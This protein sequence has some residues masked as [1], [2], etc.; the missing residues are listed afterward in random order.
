MHGIQDKLGVKNMTYLKINVTK[1][2]YDTET[3]TKGQIKKYK[4]FGKE[5]TADLTGIYIHE[6]LAF[7]IIMYS[8][9]STS[10]ECKTKLGFNPYHPVMRKEQ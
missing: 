1:D 6:D 10:V 5:F 3:F 7:K 4:R 2:I 8:T 9:V